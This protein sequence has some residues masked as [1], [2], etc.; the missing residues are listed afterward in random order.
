MDK[1]N[2]RLVIALN[3]E[4]K[5]IIELY[6]LKEDISSKYIFK[7]YKN[8]DLN[9]WLIISGIGN[10]NSAAAAIYLYETSPKKNKNIWINIGMA[11][12]FDFEI[13]SIFN[14]KKVSYKNNEKQKT[15][16]TSALTNTQIP[17]GEAMNVDNVERNFKNKNAI[18]EM[19]SYGFIKIVEKFCKRELICIIK[20]ISDNKTNIPNNFINTSKNFIE[21]NIK[22]IEGLID[23]YIKISYRL[24]E[25][26]ITTLNPIANKFHLTFSNKIIVEE[27]VEKFE[28]I[29]SKKKLT[30]LI[31]ECKT[32]KELVHKLQ[33]EI[34]D[35]M[36]E[37]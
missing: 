18:Y 5:K 16:Y 21:K 6:K 22:D 1:K 23:Q 37:I 12:S 36:L 19:E 17:I 29:Y 15:Y 4:A 3:I 2:L 25:A 31:I 26:S 34:K 24:R 27:L 32:L 9:I 10:I 30:K 35:Y 8:L 14:I 11:G 33:K 13:G 7:I 28:K 20:I